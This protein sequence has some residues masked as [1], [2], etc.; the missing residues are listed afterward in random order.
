M[1]NNAWKWW[2]VSGTYN[3][4]LKMI[5]HVFG[6]DDQWLTMMGDAYTNNEKIMETISN[7]W[8]WWMMKYFEIFKYFERCKYFE[9]SNNPQNHEKNNNVKHNETLYNTI[10]I[11][12]R[13]D[14][15]F[16]G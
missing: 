8:K 1:M 13:E 10:K 5:N 3:K 6:H 16:L 4:F 9:Y 12:N 2:T 7:D 14:Y 15:L 11:N